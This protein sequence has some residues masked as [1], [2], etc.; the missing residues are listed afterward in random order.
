MKWDKAQNR[1]AVKNNKSAYFKTKKA[2]Y[3]WWR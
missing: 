3:F 1:V 2:E